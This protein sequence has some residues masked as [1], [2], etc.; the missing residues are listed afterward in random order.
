[1]GDSSRFYILFGGL[2]FSFG[3]ASGIAAVWVL[4]TTWSWGA[5]GAMLFF[6]II[7]G[8]IG[9]AFL[10]SQ[11]KAANR[12]KRI[13]REGTRYTGK[14]YGYVEDRRIM[15]NES[16][17]VNTKVRYFDKYD[18]E[19]EAVVPTGFLKGSGDFPIGATIDIIVLD[20]DCTWVKG[21]V[22][23]VHIDREE[24]LMDNKP[25]DPALKEV[26]AVT[27]SHCA[28][29]FTATKGYVSACPYCGN[30]INC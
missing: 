26:V 13:K 22:R 3:A 15:V 18:V 14:I 21:S 1:M 28:A 20:S 8:G 24:E 30:Q 23:Y 17:P 7:F 11:I 16:Y 29:T 4:L 12:R 10:I 27:C 5:A 19:R 9:G 2:F 25:L 6:A